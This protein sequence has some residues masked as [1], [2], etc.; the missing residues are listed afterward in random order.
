MMFQFIE[1]LPGDANFHLFETLPSA[2]YGADR[3][4]LQQSDSINTEFLHTCIVLLN[5]E[6]EAIARL[7]IYNNPAL[8]YQEQKAACI[9]NF[10]CINDNAA[11]K[12]LI[13]YASNRIQ[14]DLKSPFTIGPMNGSTWD[15]YRFSNHHN[16][17]NIFLE[18]DHH[19]YYNDLFLA[20]GFQAISTY[21]SALDKQLQFDNPAIAMREQE[22]LATGVVFTNI[23]LMNFEGELEK[24]FEL[25]LSAFE[26]NFLYTPISWETF[27]KKYLEASKIMHPEHVI[28]AEDQ[29]KNCI[30]FM[31]CID[32]LYNKSEKS[33]IVKTVARINKKEWSGLG[34]VLGN[35]IT[36]RAAKEG[37]ASMI[38]AFMIEEAFSNKLSSNFLGEV[39]KNYTLFGKS[40]K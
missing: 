33:L 37:Y 30:G 20:C 10:E 36:R 16:N 39:Y 17:P 4:R 25:S 11:A 34:N 15:N 8:Y 7:A 24:I 14:T 19:L 32:D 26:K 40:T 9:G 6:K 3:L 1:T 35:M 21:K 38:H 5:N 29:A 28:L 13:E 12:A 23:D 27:K 22:L 18:P 2:L 31:F